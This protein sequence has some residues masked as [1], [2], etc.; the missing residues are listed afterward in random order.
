M[1]SHA[2]PALG[3]L[4][5][6][7]LAA[8]CS[9]GDEPQPAATPV[10]EATQRA[11]GATTVRASVEAVCRAGPF[12]AELEVRYGGRAEGAARLSRVR[13][14]VDDRLR[15]D[16]GPLDQE[17][18]LRIATFD[19]EAGSRHTYRVTAEAPGAAPAS[20]GG[21]IGCPRPRLP[22]T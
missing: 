2:L 11:G 1:R 14:F 20:I 17:S 22:E 12:G 15:E 13:L 5:V 9:D 8:A 21:A 6:A 19:V 16:S 10:A 18:Y 7:L 4:I 3:L